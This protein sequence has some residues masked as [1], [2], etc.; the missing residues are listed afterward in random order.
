MS[1]AS[2]PPSKSVQFSFR[3]TDNLITK[4]SE[5]GRR[6]KTTVAMSPSVT[7]IFTAQRM[8]DIE[9]PLVKNK[10]YPFFKTPRLGGS[11]RIRNRLV[12]KQVRHPLTYFDFITN[13]HFRVRYVYIFF[14]LLAMLAFNQFLVALSLLNKHHY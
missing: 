2:T 8:L 7:D 12:Q 13:N 1:S 3:E 6:R 9:E 14:E 10:K 11:R 5:N 4:A